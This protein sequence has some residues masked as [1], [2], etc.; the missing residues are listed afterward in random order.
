MLRM[1]LTGLLTTA[2]LTVGAAASPLG[3]GSHAAGAMTAPTD[4]QNVQYYYYGPPRRYYGPGYH[5][6]R[7]YYYRRG[8]RGDG[9]A[10][11]LAVGA[12]G[13]LAAGA[14]AGSGAFDPPPAA[15]AP[16]RR[17]WCMDRFRSYNPED[18]TYIDN[19]GR[20]RFCG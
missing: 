7:G 9:V 16:P 8:W 5:Y 19:R 13:A 11:G 1:A 15:I 4:I 10:A 6:H 18:G 17:Q 3:S 2:A 14:L 20:T 12:A